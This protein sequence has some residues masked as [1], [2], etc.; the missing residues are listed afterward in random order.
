MKANNK[1]DTICILGCLTLTI[2]GTMAAVWL[3][4]KSGV[5]VNFD[6]CEK[7]PSDAKI[8]WAKYVATDATYTWTLEDLEEAE[9]ILMEAMKTSGKPEDYRMSLW[10]VGRKIDRMKNFQ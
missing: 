9:E 3:S 6:P 2:A 8:K 10:G 4:E 1:W 7:G 5:E